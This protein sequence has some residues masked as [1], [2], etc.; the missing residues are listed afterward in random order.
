MKEKLIDLAKH[1]GVISAAMLLVGSL[2][3]YTGS[4]VNISLPP[5]KV[6]VVNWPEPTV[7]SDPYEGLDLRPPKVEQGTEV[8]PHSSLRTE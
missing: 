3:G 6:E 7:R 8:S 4:E 5:I 2:L 1:R